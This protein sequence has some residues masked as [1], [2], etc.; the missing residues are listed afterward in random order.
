MGA[1]TQEFIK[2]IM[3]NLKSNKDILE[4][5]DLA[6]T[7]VANHFNLIIS[8]HKEYGYCEVCGMTGK[9][10]KLTILVDKP[11]KDRPQYRTMDYTY[12][13]LAI[14]CPYHGT[15]RSTRFGKVI[16]VEDVEQ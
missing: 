2:F 8:Q 9:W 14:R 15:D 11:D 6:Y 7:Q 3:Q 10:V 4:F 1:L 12:D 5:L 16:K 13:I